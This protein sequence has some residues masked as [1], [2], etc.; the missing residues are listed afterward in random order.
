MMLGECNHLPDPT[1]HSWL[2]CS[3]ED[4]AAVAACTSSPERPL[5][6]IMA[7]LQLYG[8]AGHGVG[9]PAEESDEFR[10]YEFKVRRCGRGRA[11]DWTECPYAHP[12][13]KARRRDPRR[14]HYSSAACPDFRKGCCWK[15]DSC[16][17]SH[18]VFE[19]WL[20]PARYRTQP[21]KDG[22]NCGRRVCFFA[23]TPEQLRLGAAQHSPRS[24]KDQ[25]PLISSKMLHLLTSPGAI[26][27]DESPPAS[28]LAW[29]LAATASGG[30][31]VSDVILS[32][33]NL[34]LERVKSLPRTY[35]NAS[36][37]SCYGSP[38]GLLLPP[39]FQSLPSTPTWGAAAVARSGYEYEDEPPAMERVESGRSLRAMMFERLSRENSLGPAKADPSPDLDWVSELVN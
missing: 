36:S 38:R 30:S 24:P 27:P 39:G 17:F 18:G 5:L 19:C 11:H 7:A 37:G 31:P 3:G 12:G 26:S 15:G 33:R 20:H 6:D 8:S 35:S 14:H 4:T 23:H 25:S 13:E 22:T 10:M 2:S 1:D 28:P 16:E 34:Q 21:C 9:D 29:P 32:L